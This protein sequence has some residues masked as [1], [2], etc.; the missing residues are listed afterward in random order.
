MVIGLLAPAKVCPSKKLQECTNWK[1]AR[2]QNLVVK[3]RAPFY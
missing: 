1:I 2:A 3:E